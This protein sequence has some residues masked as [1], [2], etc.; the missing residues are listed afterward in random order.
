MF[1]CGCRP[2]RICGRAHCSMRWS[3]AAMP[4][5]PVTRGIRT[6]SLRP[7]CAACRQ[8]KTTDRS[9]IEHPPGGETQWDWLELTDPPQHWGFPGSA[10][11]LLG[12]L[13]HSSRWRGWI[14][15]CTDQPHLIEGLDQVTRR[16]GG[17][18]RRWRFD[19]M[20]TVCHPGSGRLTASFAPIAV[21][22]AVGIDICPSRHAWRKGAVEKSAHVIAQRWWRTLSDQASLAEAQAGLDRLCAKLDARR[23]TRNG[24]R[25]TVGAL[26]DAEPLRSAPAPFPAMFVVERTVTEQ[27]LVAFGGNQYSVPPGHA[28]EVVHVR[29]ALGAPTLDITTGRGAPLA[30]HVRAP[31][32]AGAVVRA[33]EHVKA[34]TRVVLANFS[35]RAPCARKKRR[36]PSADALAEA[37]RIRGVHAGLTGER[38][39]IDFDSYASAARPLRGAQAGSSDGVADRG[40]TS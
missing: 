8:A 12:V 4:V 10:W 22:Y 31:D 1:G 23:R 14:A 16:L 7:G 20:S 15:E 32:G 27:A 26:A 28:G 29:H 17:L 18:S 3:G 9:L 11:V 39:V 24:E 38:V 5:L 2:T 30:H 33:D 6:R 25:T 13:S 19:R 40:G 34:L 37:A 35:D 21:H 36:P